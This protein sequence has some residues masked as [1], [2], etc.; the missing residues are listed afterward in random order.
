MRCCKLTVALSSADLDEGVIRWD[1]GQ[2]Y[3]IRQ[4]ASD[5]FCVHNDPATHGCTVHAQRPLVCRKYDCRDDARVWIDYDKRIPAPLDA[6]VDVAKKEFDLMDRVQRRLLS[7]VG[8]STAINDV[9]PDADPTTGPTPAPG[10]RL[11][12][13]R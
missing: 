2:P 9:Y 11:Y 3:M 13:R 8:E 7:I 10:R 12:P 4:R 5:G 6:A 1:Y